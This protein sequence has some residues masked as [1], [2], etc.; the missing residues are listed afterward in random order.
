[1]EKQEKF[2]YRWDRSSEVDAVGKTDEYMI[3]SDHK[4]GLA[5]R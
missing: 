5:C 2:K 1:M 4:E 3:R